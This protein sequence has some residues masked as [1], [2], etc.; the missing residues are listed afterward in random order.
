MSWEN[1]S[2]LKESHPIETSE[3]AKIIGV[4]HEPAFNWWVPR[5]LNKRDRIILLLKKRNPRFLKKTHKFGIEV[6]KTVKDALT[7]AKS[8]YG[9]NTH[10]G[11]ARHKA[12]C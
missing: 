10:F 7:K 6:P 8:L 5:V 1:L 4:D 12:R 3:Y 2:N 11:R 9:T